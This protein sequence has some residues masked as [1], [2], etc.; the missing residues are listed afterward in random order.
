[1]QAPATDLCA[2]KASCERVPCG[3]NATLGITRG[4]CAGATGGSCA[5]S[6][7]RRGLACVRSEPLVSGPVVVSCPLLTFA[8]LLAHHPLCNRHLTLV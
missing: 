8:R 4:G 3:V 5:V 2:E 7:A 1:M 6:D